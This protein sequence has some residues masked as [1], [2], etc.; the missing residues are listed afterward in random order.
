MD[1]HEKENPN[2]LWCAK[3]SDVGSGAGC[4]LKEGASKG[5][6]AGAAVVECDVRRVTAIEEKERGRDIGEELGGVHRAHPPGLVLPAGWWKGRHRDMQVFACIY[7]YRARECAAQNTARG[8]PVEIDGGQG[9]HT[10]LVLVVA[11]DAWAGA[12]EQRDIVRVLERP[13]ELGAE[14]LW[15]RTPMPWL[16]AYIGDLVILIILRAF[17]S[18]P[19]PICALLLRTTILCKH[20]PSQ[21]ISVAS[22]SYSLHNPSASFSQTPAVYISHP[23]DCGALIPPGYCVSMSCVDHFTSPSLRFRRFTATLTRFSQGELSRTKHGTGKPTK[24]TRIRTS[25]I[26]SPLLHIHRF[27]TDSHQSPIRRRPAVGRLDCIDWGAPHYFFPFTS[28]PHLILRTLGQLFPASYL[29]NLYHGHLLLE[30][31]SEKRPTVHRRRF[32]YTPPPAPRRIFLESSARRD[33]GASR[34][35]R[36]EPP[37]YR[38][39]SIAVSQET[40]SA[41][42]I[43]GRGLA[44][45]GPDLGSRGPIA[46]LTLSSRLNFQGSFC[47]RNSVTVNAGTPAPDRA[48]VTNLLPPARSPLPPVFFEF[49][50][51]T[52]LNLQYS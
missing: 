48:E 18:H 13:T 9:T 52:R 4:G 33:M 43:H 39:G 35:V 26:S 30:S 50:R 28:T 8:D 22:L 47:R 24:Q 41:P 10:E 31:G 40:A 38:G 23:M 11:V 12:S 36:A 49:I 42:P 51:I 19:L 45:P 37:F 7:V 3:K 14:R 1:P 2:L 46:T 32:K 44:R 6:G 25:T 15:L 21:T 29:D 5:K 20:L 34:R 27:I 17:S 16:A